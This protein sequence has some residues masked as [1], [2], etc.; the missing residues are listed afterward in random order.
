M[1]V[2]ILNSLIG[3]VIYKFCDLLKGGLFGKL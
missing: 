2:I 1:Y 3:K